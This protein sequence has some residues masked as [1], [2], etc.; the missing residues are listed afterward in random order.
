MRRILFAAA[1]NAAALEA[2]AQ[3]APQT[4]SDAYTRY[5]LLAPGTGKFRIIYEVTATTPGATHY[6]NP[7]RPGS[8]ASDESVSD[9]ATGKPL[10]F[11]EVGGAVARLNG[12]PGADTSGRYIE[13]TLS[14]P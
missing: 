2:T 9:R 1:L 7:I 12:L 13:V 4:E 5:E 14:R 11:R 6:Y 3:A 10:V 8:V